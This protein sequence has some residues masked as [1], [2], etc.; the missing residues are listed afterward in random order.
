MNF[1]EAM[2]E[3]QLGKK[4]RRKSW[5]EGDFWHKVNHR[6]RHSSGTEPYFTSKQIAAT[7]WVIV[8]EKLCDDRVMELSMFLINF[9]KELKLVTQQYSYLETKEI[10]RSLIKIMVSV[11]ITKLT[12]DGVHHE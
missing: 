12:K 11:E 7:D 2:Q 6:I 4:V 5:K 1:A 3:V 8:T 10:I 9:N